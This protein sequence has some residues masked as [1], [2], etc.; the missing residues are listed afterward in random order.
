M[1]KSGPLSKAE[2]FYIENNLSLTV[3]ELCLDLNRPKTTVEKFLKTIAKNGPPVK[4][5]TLLMKQFANNKKGSVVMTENASS[6]GDDLRRQRAKTIQGG[7]S[8]TTTIRNV[9]NK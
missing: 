9:D 6:M 4:A 2:R 7:N 8:R 3:D 1:T 5:E